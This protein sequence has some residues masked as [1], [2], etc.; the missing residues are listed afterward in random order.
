MRTRS[1]WSGAREVLA[2]VLAVVYLGVPTYILINTVLK[3]PRDQT[4]PLAPA[5]PATLQ[6]FETALR[7][8]NVLSALLTSVS[9]TAISVVLVIAFAAL[10]SYPL[11]RVTRR[12]SRLTF[13]FF[14]AGLVV[15]SVGIIPLYINM[16]KIGLVG[17]PVALILIYIAGNL[18]F[19]ILLYT[20]FLRAMP[21]D[22]EEA[23]RL[24][25]AGHLRVFW[26]VVFP[27]LRP[28]T[29]T[30]AVLTVIAVYNDFMMP[31]LYLTGSEFTTLPLALRTFS[32]QYTTDWS[33]IFSGVVI[34]V[35]PV[36]LFYIA[37]QRTIIRG[38]AGG[39]KG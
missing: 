13:A 3:G 6:S 10:A 27:L 17:S 12:W 29:G 20:V 16:L 28:V 34:G 35:L 1:R 18:P 37:L 39:L 25:G 5:N 31:L 11:A 33:A 7:E 26:S 14:V 30:I 8:G 21:I 2:W 4:S 19:S 32:S 9:I 36:L 15:P 23:A 38:F 24:D 22:Y